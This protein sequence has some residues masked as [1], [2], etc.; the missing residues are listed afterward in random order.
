MM[1]SNALK[2]LHHVYCE[3]LGLHPLCKGFYYTQS[4]REVEGEMERERKRKVEGE[5]ERERKRKPETE[6]KKESERNRSTLRLN[7]TAG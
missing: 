5:M 3:F 4:L 2:R 7:V 6:R 1:K